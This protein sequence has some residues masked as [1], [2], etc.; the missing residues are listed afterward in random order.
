MCGQYPIS[1][2]SIPRGAL[3]THPPWLI[4]LAVAHL[5][6][7]CHDELAQVP[8][9]A[10]WQSKRLIMLS[11]PSAK[12]WHWKAKLRWKIREFL[13]K[14]ENIE[15]PKKWFPIWRFE[16]RSDFHRT[17]YTI[18]HKL[19]RNICG[20]LIKMERKSVFFVNKRLW[21]HLKIKLQ[22]RAEI[23]TS[24]RKKASEFHADAFWFSHF[25]SIVYT[26]AL[27]Q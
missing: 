10:P 4:R 26:L 25:G 24:D 17:F 8:K 23:T 16:K 7:L 11:S 20:H 3:K 2:M 5:H 1:P 13:T 27:S 18:L 15:V 19:S 12:Q 22:N 9:S 6:I 21:G 14:E